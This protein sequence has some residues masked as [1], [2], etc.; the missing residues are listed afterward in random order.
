[1]YK[2]KHYIR[3]ATEVAEDNEESI[4]LFLKHFSVTSVYSVANLDFDYNAL[5][6]VFVA[7]MFKIPALHSGEAVWQRS[8]RSWT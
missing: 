6:V 2:Q 1:M 8:D 7:F 3:C 4:K 5:S